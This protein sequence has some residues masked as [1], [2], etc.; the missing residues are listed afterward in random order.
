MAVKSILDI[1][2]NDGPF[3]DFAALFAKYD[4]ALKKTPD[5]W[6]K[7][8]VEIGGAKTTFDEMVAK[9]VGARYLRPDQRRDPDAI[10]K[11]I[12]QM[13]LDLRN[14]NGRWDDRK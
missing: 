5:S 9:L 12:E 3:K 2:V 14:G 11:A 7:I 10:T 1:Q 13:K 6:K 8:S 4:A